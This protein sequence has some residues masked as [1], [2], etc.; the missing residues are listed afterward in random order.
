MQVQGAQEIRDCP[1]LTMKNQKT[2]RIIDSIKKSDLPVVIF[3][4]GIV[5]EVMYHAC[6]DVGIEVKC[7]CD[8]NVNKANTLKC[9]IEVAHTPSLKKE[10]KDAVFLISSA[11]I[12]DVISQL[13]KLGFR[14]WNDCGFILRG[15]DLSKHEYSM[16]P[17]FVEYASSTCIL[18]HDSYLN[19]EKLFMRS[20]DIIITE[21]CSLKCKDCSNLMQYYVKPSDCSTDDIMKTI[22]QFLVVV[23]E[24]N[25]F[26]VIGGEPFMNKEWPRI[27]KKLNGEEKVRKVV[28]YTNGT[29]APSVDNLDCLKG[30]KVLVLV[31]DYGKLSNNILK[32]SELFDRNGIAYYVQKAHGWT[33]CSS[34][35]PHTRTAEAQRKL[36]EE[37]CARNTYTLSDGGLFRCPFSANAAR[38]HAIP[39]LKG[40]HVALDFKHGTK[41]D[42]RLKKRQIRAFIYDKSYL[43][44]CDFCNGRVFGAS[45][46]I[47]AIQTEQPINYKDYPWEK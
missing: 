1:E 21:R 34:I 23:D 24:V 16:P 17:D 5:G 18:C 37:C 26:R 30:S 4:A 3:G 2:S 11:D 35:T 44:S 32:M 22:D 47:P 33:S 8:N 41:N 19:P 15:F 20:V 42:L 7:F 27:I 25:E 38:L 13:D 39:D 40:D 45:E 36:F 10:F 28:I 43:D 14:K 12:K 46:I 29:I 9:G 6:R 31:T